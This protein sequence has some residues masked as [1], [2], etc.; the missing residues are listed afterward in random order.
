MKWLKLVSVSLLLIVVSSNVFASDRGN[1]KIYAET[2]LQNTAEK[3]IVDVRSAEEFAQG[4]VPGA[5]NIPHNLI[6]SGDADLDKLRDKP[7]VVYC[8]SGRRAEL[9]IDAMQ[10]QGLSELFHL[11]G[12]MLG[13]QAAELPI[14]VPKN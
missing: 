11:E 10:S 12:D 3:V 14:E 5:I 1:N 9:A 2:L 4:H 8:R 7:V 13:W 6:L